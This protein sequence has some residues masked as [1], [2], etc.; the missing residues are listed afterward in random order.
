MK[1]RLILLVWAVLSCGPAFAQKTAVTLNMADYMMLGTLN[2]G[3]GV[4][5]ARHWTLEAAAKYNPFS[6]GP[7]ENRMQNRQQVYN[8]G[9]R[10]WPWHVFSGWWISAKAQYQEYKVNRRL[11]LEFGLSGWAGWDRYAV[12]ECPVCGFTL[13]R[14]QKVF[15][16]PNELVLALTYVF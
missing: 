5:V 13:E 2:V 15:F 7:E 12:Y 8:A 6:Y 9:V 10:Y 14:G 1:R 16:L 11:N 4:S 3:A